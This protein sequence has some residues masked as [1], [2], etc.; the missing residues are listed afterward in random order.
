M[1]GT[2][3]LSL[4]KFPGA[5]NALQGTEGSRAGGGGGGECSIEYLQEAEKKRREVK[6][7]LSPRP[8]GG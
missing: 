3:G 6:V 7:V 1:Y 2:Y 5:G 8:T 4:E